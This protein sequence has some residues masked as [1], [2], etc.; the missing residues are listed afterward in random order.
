M[1]EDRRHTKAF[2]KRLNV[3][4]GVIA[5]GAEGPEIA[6]A[7]YASDWCTLA[8][9]GDK[10]RPSGGAQFGCGGHDAV[11]KILA[12]EVPRWKGRHC[13][14][15]SAGSTEDSVSSSKYDV[16]GARPG[17]AV[18][19]DRKLKHLHGDSYKTKLKEIW[20][21]GKGSPLGKGE[22]KLFE[23]PVY[24][25][26]AAKH[27]LCSRSAFSSNH[28]KISTRGGGGRQLNMFPPLPSSMAK[29]LLDSMRNAFKNS[30]TI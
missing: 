8:Q 27:P 20:S 12:S 29:P 11:G 1:A 9:S 15:N 26:E 4:R 28:L 18:G 13:F 19:V 24:P 7:P 3:L 22:K 2:I 10:Y 21:A 25:K 6:Q 17:I 14:F 5:P 23:P 30:Y 16:E